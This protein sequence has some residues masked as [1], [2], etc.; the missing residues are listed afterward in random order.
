MSVK[1][2]YNSDGLI[3]A[4]VQDYKTN[5]V[6]M[7]AYMNAVSLKLTLKTKKVHFYSRSRNKLWLKGESSG[8]IQKLKEIYFDCDLDAVLV[9]IEQV[10]GAACH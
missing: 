2:K 5:E 8:N 9:K 6:L 7:L 1:V 10:G 4:I 3:P